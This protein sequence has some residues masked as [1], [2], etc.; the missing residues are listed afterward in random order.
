MSRAFWKGYLKLSLVSCPVALYPAVSKTQRPRF[1]R[2]HKQS[3]HRLRQ[4]MVEPGTLEPVREE[5]IA[6]GYEAPRSSAALSRPREATRAAP[7]DYTA[8]QGYIEVDDKD[9]ERIEVVKTHTIDIER[10]V[11]RSEIDDRYLNAPYYVTLSGE[12]GQEAY[13]VMRDAMK[14]RQVAG[15]ARIVLTRRE[16]LVMIEPFGSGLLAVTLRNR[17]EVRDEGG[18][19]RDI[20]DSALAQGDARLG[21]SYRGQNEGPV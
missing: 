6:R 17:Y 20:K 14:T 9:L 11:P 1:H 2:I 5:D 3:G 15:L 4:L 7:Q 19:F 8:P 13:A 18:C 12:A 16:H 21:R 10:F